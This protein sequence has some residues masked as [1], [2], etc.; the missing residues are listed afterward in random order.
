MRS[1]AKISELI[2]GGYPCP[3]VVSGIY[4]VQNIYNQTVLW[5]F[6]HLCMQEGNLSAHG[7]DYIRNCQK[8]KT[9]KNHQK[10]SKPSTPLHALNE[11]K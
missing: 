6:G 4:G 1:I 10:P 11:S 2:P 3:T 8:P 9:I 7:A 5:F